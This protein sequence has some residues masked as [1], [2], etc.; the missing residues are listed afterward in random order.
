MTANGSDPPIAQE[1]ERLSCTT[2][3]QRKL[4][5]NKSQPC[6]N[7]QK[8]GFD[9]A[10]P[11]GRRP[12]RTSRSQLVRRLQ[13][14]ESNLQALAKSLNST[15][16]K[17]LAPRPAHVQLETP[18]HD[19]R[20]DE[21]PSPDLAEMVKDAGRLSISADESRYSSHTLW[22]SLSH[23]VCPLCIPSTRAL[24]NAHR[25]QRCGIFWTRT[26]ARR[27]ISPRR[28]ALQILPG[29]K[30]YRHRYFLG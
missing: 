14:V 5:C 4:R 12:P 17:P 21:N 26:P 7:C 25:L 1:I 19:A 10:Y 24:S 3:R 11:S 28:I 6:I 9:C 23:E 27:I 16:A 2:C 8:A 18:K 30:S 13:T 20:L 22:A 15:E 29:R